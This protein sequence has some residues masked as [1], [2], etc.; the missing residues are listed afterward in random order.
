MLGSHHCAVPQVIRYV[1]PSA[2]VPRRVPC[3]VMS[4]QLVIPAPTKEPVGRPLPSV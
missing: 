2:K 3:I 4:E 1:L